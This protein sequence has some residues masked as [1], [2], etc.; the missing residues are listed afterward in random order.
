VYLDAGTVSASI[1]SATGGNFESLVASTAAAVSSITDDSDLTTVSLTAGSTAL[2]DDSITYTA[3]LTSAAQSQVLVTLSSGSVITIAS[4][5]S[6]GTVSVAAPTVPGTV[7]TTISSASGGNFESLVASTAAAVVSIVAA[8]DAPVNTVPGSVFTTGED[9][10]VAITGLSVADED[11]A[12][13]V[14]SVT[15][16]VT[17]GALMVSG[18]TATISGNGSSSVILTGTLAQINSTLAASI[19]FVPV[20]DFSGSATLTM[21]TNDLGN[22]GVGGPK[23]DIDVVSITVNS[24]VD[25]ADDSATTSE[26]TPV[27]IDVLANDSFEDSGRAITAV[28]GLAITAGGPAVAVAN[29]TVTLTVGGQLVFTPTANYSGGPI[30][31]T[32]TVTSGGATETATVNITSITAV[33]DT[34]V[35]TTGSTLAYTENDSAAAINTTIT[36]TDVDNTTLSTGTVSIT[37]NFVSGQDVLSFTNVPASMGNITGSYNA[38]TGVMSLSSAGNTATTAQWQAALRAVLYSNSSDNPSTLDRTVSYTVNDSAAN[39][40]TV[41]STISVAPV[42]DAPVLATGSTLGYTENGAA[43]AI[44]TT[45]TVADVDNTTLSTGTVS[46]T[47]NFVSGQDVLSFTNVPA[48]MGNITGS[49]NAATGVMSL[50]S[51]GN[52]ATTAQ[53]QAAFRAVQYSNSSDNP[54]VLARTVS[55]TVNDSAANSN[56]VTSTINITAANDAPV[57]DLDG[58]ATGITYTTT[59]F[60]GPDTPIRVADTDFSLT[61]VDSA[62]LNRLRLQIGNFQGG[63]MLTFTN[64]GNIT[65]TYNSGSGLLTLSGVDTV[66][67]YQAALDAVRF[68]TTSTNNTARTVTVT[69]RDSSG[70]S[71]TGAVATINI[72]TSTT[73]PTANAASATG[74]EDAASIPITLS[75]A[76]PDGL[77]TVLTIATVPNAATQ[78]TLYTDAS[79]T[80]AVTAG[81]VINVTDA[82]SVSYTLYFVPIANYNGAPT[83]TYTATDNAGSPNTSAAATATITVNAV[84]DAPTNTVPGAQAGTEDT[85]KVITGLSVADVDAAAGTMTVTLSVT[86]GTITHSGGTGGTVSGSGTSTVTITG[87]LSQINSRLGG[88]ITYVPTADFNGTATLT[89]TTSDGGNTGSGGTLIDVDTIA[90]NVS[91]VADIT[92]DTVSTTEDTPISFNAITGTGGATADSFENAGRAVTSVTQG[93][94]GT[95]S[96]TAAGVLTYTPNPDYNGSDSFTYTVTSGGVTETATVNVT[97]SAINDAPVNTVPTS[98]TVLEDTLAVI[99]GISVGDVDAASSTI[100]VT[101]SVPTGSLLATTS[102][103]VTVTGNGT[104]SLLL[105]GTQANI[106]AF[107]AA[108]NVSFQP[109]ANAAGTVTLT[110][111]TSDLGNTGTGGTLTDVDTVALNIQGVND[112]PILDLDANNNTVAGSGYNTFFSLGAPAAVAIV[113]TDVSVTDSDSINIVSATITLTNAQAGDTLAVNAASLP[114]GISY[115]VA[116]NVVTLTG[117]TFKTDYQ[118][119]LQAVTFNTTSPDTTARTITVTV[120]D[121]ALDSN[122]A[123]TTIT[124]VAANNPPVAADTTSPGTEDTLVPVTLS[125]TDTDGSVGAFKLTSL[126]ANGA[127]YLDAAMTTLAPIGMSIAATGSGPYTATLYFNPNPNWNGSTSFAYTA[128]DNLG[129]LDATPNTATITV[130]AVNDGTTV[131]NNDSYTLPA[132]TPYTFTK[133]SL[134]ANDALYDRAAITGS[135]G[136][137]TLA[138]GSGTLVDNGDGTYTFTPS[139]T[140]VATFTY[141]V[142]EDTGQTSSATVTLNVVAAADDFATVQES[143]LSGGTGGGATVVSGNVFSNDSGNTSIS[144]I[145]TITDGGVGD[146]DTR[147]G[148]IGVNDGSGILA[149]DI[150]G[151]GAGDY[152]YTLNSRATN[153]APGSATDT[154]VVKDFAYVANSTNAS[155]HVTI[156]DDRPIATSATIQVP[157]ST[158]PKFSLVLCLDIS[159]SMAAPYGAVKQVNAD[160]SVTTTDRYTLA[161]QALVALVEEYFAQSPDVSVKLV[162]FAAT[163]TIIGG[164]SGTAYTDLSSAVTAINGI[165]APTG[166]T[167]YSDALTKIQTA[168]GTPVSGRDSIVYFLSDGVPSA[169]NTTDPA[170]AGSGYTTYLNNN[171]DLKSF[172]VGIGTGISTV[173]FLDQISRVDSLGDGVN[174]PAIMVPDL[175]QLSTQLLSTVPQGFGG[176][177]VAAGG[178]Q[179]ASFGADG[180]QVSTIT[181]SL[182]SNGDQVPDTAV[183]FSYN[184]T[185]ITNNN[186]TV[187]G[188]TVT[189]HMLTLDAARNFDYGSLVFDFSSGAYTYYTGG[190]AVNGTSFTLQS[191]ITD[192]EGDLASS[193]QTISV[194]DGKPVAHSDADTMFAKQ[195]SMEGNVVTGAGTDAGIAIGSQ[196]TPFTV[197]GSGVDK[198]VDNATVT[199]IDF[200][201][202]HIDLTTNVGSTALAGGTYTVTY[203]ATTDIH[204]MSWTNATT[205]SSLTFNS[206]GHYEYTPATADLPNPTTSPTNLTV[207]LTSAGAVSTGNLTLEGM[208]PG[209]TTANAVVT[210]SASGAGVTGGSNSAAVDGL[211]WLKLTFNSGTYTNGVQNVSFVINAA[212]SNLGPPGNGADPAL[213]YKVYG[214]DGSFLGQ[215]SSDQENTVTVPSTYSHIGWIIIEAAGDAY[216]RVQSV[217]FSGVQNNAAASAIPEEIIGYTLT[218]DNGDTSSAA[219]TLN[220]ITNEYVD[221]AATNSITGSTGN[222]RIQGLGGDDTLSGGLGNDLVEGGDGSDSLHGDGGSDTLSGG[223][224]SD[225]LFGDGGNDVLR[226]GDGGDTLDGGLGNDRLEAGAGNDSLTG[227]DGSDTLSGGA[228]NDTLTGGLLSD[229]FEWTLADAGAKGTPAVDT[230]TDFNTAAA[231]SGGDVLDLRDLLSGENHSTATGNLANFLSFEKV[232]GDTKVHISSSGGFAGGFNSGAED[233]TVVLQG[234]DLYASV[235]VNATDQ[236]IIQDLLNKGKLITD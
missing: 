146:V 53:W 110:V 56:T 72:A 31:F 236:Q 61:D 156:E 50:S 25:I 204:T 136:P 178:T 117:S 191:V 70:L 111:T 116:G 105:A 88:T 229:T 45:I 60:T 77:V 194:V 235:G 170:G 108:S 133:A 215:F 223:A 75:A 132:G 63:D 92:N 130:A 227:G 175:N 67:N 66:A 224:G 44:N 207:N 123:T 209:S 104:G 87:T 59:Y 113:D 29:G 217:T 169:G 119:A 34:P 71:G 16:N 89:M 147:A 49:Y 195:S 131:A 107:I 135:A 165:S 6:S 42:N 112:A 40:N 103:G 13:G 3:S 118:T 106:N 62:N 159:G 214:I 164:G 153:G 168:M 37:T 211:E 152:T 142:Q 197:Q 32:Y 129:A 7:S 210:Y 68:Y 200:K 189:G 192:V 101:L 126:P 206:T 203:N 65:G 141:T 218:D 52:T 213:T 120:N 179:T 22:T 212:N 125:A 161:K 231:P 85:G 78:G 23:T 21:T 41:T 180:G 140:G 55:Y 54:S 167:N 114:P 81:T 109:A 138:S 47:T 20:A 79:L 12:S 2:E 124:M 221:T 15:L 162:Q 234:V 58:S 83:F 158:T 148:Y 149:V 174:D 199:S 93:A 187:A 121:G 90:I 5:S 188:G 80:T 64:I 220:I 94:N 127:L 160:G 11:V 144:S 91:A 176:S 226:G 230:I 19:N 216:A 76:D 14:M 137:V 150:T 57:I 163:A 128:V 8:N 43:A 171:P 36:V 10:S 82:A 172:A 27:T 1:S 190:T 17:N 222:D 181:I 143:A 4:G 74:N 183:T 196:A 154:A 9:S 155:L 51:A 28:D 115:S 201:G 193:V 98:I 39:S 177:V 185:Q 33:N 122:T 198:I 97:V 35:L 225:Q 134:L 202:T 151:A 73:V 166:G 232:G 208:T 30:S 48:S 233:Q 139:G 18:G 186:N 184:G 26:D 182:D 95:V 38:T 99:T 219:L 157:E 84:N 46:I 69:P 173:T 86:N 24:V 205:G 96:F 102:G 228:G 145:N 100:N